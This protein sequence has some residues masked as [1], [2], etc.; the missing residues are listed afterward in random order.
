MRIDIRA[1]VDADIENMSRVV[2]ACWNDNFSGFLSK[3]AIE[4]FT[5]EHRRAAFSKQLSE[6]AVI[7]LLLL[8]GI[9]SAVCAGSARAEN[10]H[11][12]CFEI[13][14]L[15]VAPEHQRS[16]LGRKLLMHTLRQARKSGFKC[17]ALETAV[18]NTAARRFYEKFGFRQLNSMRSVNGIDYAAYKIEF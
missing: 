7:N 3:E 9:I 12:Q 14:Q 11:A 18:Q 17:A 1:A 10:P 16:G 13:V 15:Y 4:S 6:G 8:D 5:G 2:D